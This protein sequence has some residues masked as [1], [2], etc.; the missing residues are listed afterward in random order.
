MPHCVL[1][2]LFNGLFEII[3]GRVKCLHRKE[4]DEEKSSGVFVGYTQI[5]FDRIGAHYYGYILKKRRLKENISLNILFKLYLY[6]NI[7]LFLG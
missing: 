7:L 6:I 1:S 5:I 2:S 3:G 4:R